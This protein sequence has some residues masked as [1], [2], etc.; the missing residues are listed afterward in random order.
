[1]FRK[2]ELYLKKVIYGQ[3]KGIVPYF[4][5][6]ILLP[7]SWIFELV[8]V[9]RNWLYDQGWMR[10]YVPPVPLVI[11]VGNIVAGGTG[12]T[13]VTLLLAQLF[14]DKF[15]VAILSR[16]YRSKAEHLDQPVI[17]SQGNGPI[18][19]AAY[20]GDEPYLFAQRLPKAYVIVGGNRQKASYMAAKLGAQIILLD[21]GMQHRQLVRDFDV[22]VIDVKDPFGQGY[23][24]PRG[25]L[26]EDIRS[27]SRA[28][29]IILN[30]IQTNE[31]FKNLKKQIEAYTSAPIV[32]SRWG[33]VKILDLKKHTLPSLK[34]KKVGIF[35]GIAHPEYFKHTIQKLDAEIVTE[36][37]LSDHEEIQEKR[38]E[39]F[40]Q[41]CIQ[42]GA[43]WL[44]CTEK[45]KVKLSDSFVCPLPIAWLQMEL[46]IVE[47]KDEWKK[48]LSKAE[49][50]IF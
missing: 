25:F 45:D 9:C 38:L 8:I 31:E 33:V 37:F 23:F 6:L 7:L 27:L 2:L 21:D 4:V 18:F 46:E 40:A 17:L 11:S 47:G 29:L 28:Q 35:C 49:A 3:N 22:V 30:H 48:F 15:S 39:K 41:E 5:K 43:Q 50:R 10:R 44:V 34:G 36:Y 20:C 12:K 32:G 13:P 19:P 26:R 16:G 1:M 14:Y 42:K 24:L